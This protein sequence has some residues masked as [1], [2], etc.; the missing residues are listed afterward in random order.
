MGHVFRG[1]ANAKPSKAQCCTAEYLKA[2]DQGFG[3]CTDE[4]HCV[5]S[6]SLVLRPQYAQEPQELL[7]FHQRY[8]GLGS[9]RLKAARQLRRHTQVQCLGLPG[10]LMQACSAV[11]LI[12]GDSKT[13]PGSSSAAPGNLD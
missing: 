11:C 5:N 2:C 7:V 13:M 12:V 9:C 3:Y 8:F 4:R 6:L 1:E 10:M